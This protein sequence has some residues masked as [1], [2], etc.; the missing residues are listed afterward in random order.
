MK[1]FTQIHSSS[2]F[3]SD[4]KTNNFT[5]D[6]LH[7]LISFWI[8]CALN[9][10]SCYID[11]FNWTLNIFFYFFK[12]LYNL[13]F[14][15]CVDWTISYLRFDICV[16]WTIW[17][18]AISNQAFDC[19]GMPQ[20]SMFI[21]CNGLAAQSQPHFSMP[22]FE[23]KKATFPIFSSSTFAFSFAMVAFLLLGHNSNTATINILPLHDIA[24]SCYLIFEICPWMFSD[25]WHLLVLTHKFFG[26]RVL[27]LSFCF[28]LCH[29]HHS[30]FCDPTDKFHHAG[31]QCVPLPN[32]TAKFT[33]ACL[34]ST[35]Q[36]NSDISQNTTFCPW[37][38]W[39]CVPP[40]SQ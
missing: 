11:M 35:Y 4:E 38:E 29:V 17:S 20:T 9:F 1:H 6:M 31:S 8:W 40:S 30:S 2:P 33:N 16:D 21:F 3:G 24:H 39:H 19:F 7:Q 28:C 34:M 26:S 13:I 27:F 25:V 15:I 37:Q 14:D 23:S 18:I 12:Q 10:A 22:T 32:R 5:T 36:C